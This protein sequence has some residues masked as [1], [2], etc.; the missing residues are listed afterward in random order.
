VAYRPDEI[1]YIEADRNY[2]DVHL[3][4]GKKQIVSMQLGQIEKAI[5]AAHFF[6]INRS[7]I[8]NL[9]YFTHADQKHKKCFLKWVGYG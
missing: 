3:T 1:L 4:N 6:R 7:V 9:T 2:S 8:I 5:P